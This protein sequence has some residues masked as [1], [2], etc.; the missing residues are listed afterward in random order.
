MDALTDLLLIEMPIADQQA[1]ESIYYNIDA[2]LLQAVGPIL[3]KGKVELG[4][5]YPLVL[6]CSLRL[7]AAHRLPESHSSMR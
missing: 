5:K 4:S 7:S 6:R 3:R 2:F 1:S